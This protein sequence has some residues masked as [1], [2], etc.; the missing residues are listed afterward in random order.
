MPHLQVEENGLVTLN[1]S[2]ES[3]TNGKFDWPVWTRFLYGSDH[4]GSVGVAS[5][6]EK[7]ILTWAVTRYRCAA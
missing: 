1:K 3:K 6:E 5:F 2:I 4:E 7:D